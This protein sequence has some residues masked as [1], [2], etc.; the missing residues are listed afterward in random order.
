[1]RGFWD[2]FGWIKNGLKNIYQHFPLAEITV[3]WHGTAFVPPT[4]EAGAVS[5]A[6]RADCWSVLNSSLYHCSLNCV[7]GRGK[8]SKAQAGLKGCCHA[9]CS[10]LSV[11]GCCGGKQYRSWFKS[12]LPRWWKLRT[13]S[14]FLTF[15][16]YCSIIKR[17]P[18][19]SCALLLMV[20]SPA[21]EICSVLCEKLYVLFLL[22]WALC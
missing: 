16:W 11:V 1:M 10:S 14:N 19:C 6:G 13:Q 18:R 21:S 2:G 22:T 17:P 5:V 20:T 15:F 9:V 12:L 3:K 8:L 7:S 4:P